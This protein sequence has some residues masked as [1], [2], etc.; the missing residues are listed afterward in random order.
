MTR[1]FVLVFGL[2]LS[3]CSFAQSFSG[4]K[5]IATIPFYDQETDLGEVKVEIE[6][7]KLNWVD[8]D[9]LMQILGNVLKDD[10][11]KAVQNLPSELTP[12]R[13]PFPLKFNPS[14]LKLEATINLDQRPV[15]KTE[16]GVDLD[17]EKRVALRP[18]PIGGALNYRVEQNWGADRLGGDYFSGQFSPFI[19]FKSVVL[20]NQTFYQSNLDSKWYRGDTRLVKDLE[21]QNIRSQIGDVYPQIQGFMVA[22]PLGGVN[23]QRNFSLNPYRLPYPTGNQTFTLRARSFVKYF[24][25]SALVKS[26]Y[27]QAGNYSAKD[28]PLNN[29]LNTITIEA[30]DDLGQKQFFTFKASSNINLLNEG[31]S[32]FDVSY[33]TP[34]LDTNFKREYR[35]GDGKIFSGFYQYGFSSLFSGSAYLQNQDVF[36]L[37][38]TEFIQAVPIGN[39]TFGTARSNQDKLEGYASSLGYQLITQGKKWFDSH[40]FALRFENKSK[41]FRTSLTD[42]S[43]AVQNAYAANYTIPV[44]NLFTFSLGGNYGDVRNND[45][46][47][48]YGYDLN[49]SF[50]ILNQHNLAFF[51]SRNRDEF[52]NWNDVAYVFLTFT[53][54][55]SNSYV[56]SLYDQKQK[57]MRVNVLRD[58]QNQLYSPRTQAIAEYSEEVQNGEVD[59]NYPT[60]FGDLGGRFTG[61]KT[62][63]FDTAT[64][65]SVRVNSAFVFAFQDNEAGFGVSRPIPGSFVIFKPEE[66]LKDQKIA[67]KSTSPF[68]EAQS[69]LFDEIV[70]SNLIAYQ[71]RDVQLDPTMLEAGRS[72]EKEKFMLYPT[73]RSAHLVKLHERGAVILTGKLLN[74][75]GAPLALQV[76][77]I[78]S[79]PFFTNRDGEIFVEGVEAGTHEMTIEGRDDKYTFSVSKKE[80]GFKNLGDIKFKENEL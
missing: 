51:V 13:L 30:T 10:T 41:G 50:R 70:F 57:S 3:F 35:E 76:G 20:E 18:A 46:E 36:N 64:R 79:V 71:Y 69:G 27:L 28:I 24:V 47:N 63:V 65:G 66:R 5:Y 45:L 55:E 34:F 67:L 43:S 38:G 32:R 17:E 62:E 15:K 58:N 78:G 77:Q 52:K 60:Q 37:Y 42:L 39:I 75:D 16:L 1:I 26:E 33:G 14:E 72:L 4:Q 59:I 9:S 2:L 12:E 68:T 61:N 56:S 6:G 49:L 53:I 54:P 25:N 73:Y 48:R 31:E 21:K 22:R 19:N 74:I 44:S 8:R 7:E 23:I 29:G 11:L 80:H 40:T